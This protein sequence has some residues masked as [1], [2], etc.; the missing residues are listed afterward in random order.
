MA[1]IYYTQ[2]HEWIKIDA[3]NITVGITDF[4][5]QQLGDIVFVE[6]PV[7]GDQLFTDKFAVVIESVKAAGEVNSP[8]NGKV[9]AINTALD[10]DPELINR[11]PEAEGWLFKLIVQDPDTSNFMD[12]EAYLKF[13]N[14][15]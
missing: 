1:I 9:I 3:K 6:L 14:K 15:D 10:S 2:D 12:S 5:Q 4:A 11:D 13:M 8:M 7:I